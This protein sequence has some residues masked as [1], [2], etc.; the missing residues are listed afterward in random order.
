ME[1]ERRG[2]RLDT[3]HVGFCLAARDVMAQTLGE[4]FAI[5]CEDMRVFAPVNVTYCPPIAWSACRHLTR[6]L[7]TTPALFLRGSIVAT[8]R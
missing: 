8:I 5:L 1:R 3:E 4:F 2:L 6:K 7:M